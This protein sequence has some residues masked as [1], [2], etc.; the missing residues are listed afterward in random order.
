MTTVRLVPHRLATI[1]GPQPSPLAAL[2]GRLRWVAASRW[3]DGLLDFAL[4]RLGPSATETTPPDA[5]GGATSRRPPTTLCWHNI[6]WM[7]RA[8][9]RVE[10]GRDRNVP[11]AGGRG[12]RRTG[13]DA[14]QGRA[15]VARAPQNHTRA[16]IAGGCRHP[17]LPSA[18]WEGATLA[19]AEVVIRAAVGRWPRGV[20]L[21]VDPAVRRPVQTSKCNRPDRLTAAPGGTVPRPAPPPSRLSPPP[22]SGGRALAVAPLDRR[23]RRLRTRPRRIRRPPAA[24]CLLDVPTGPQREAMTPATQDPRAAERHCSS[25]PLG[26]RPP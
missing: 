19:L 26:H 23:W 15:Q 4:L 18:V 3:L 10:R 25:P 14:W 1:C 11:A 7:R 22:H 8:P 6:Y 21:P 9:P 12:R 2:M 5:R 24:R 20:G 16:V 17:R 13:L